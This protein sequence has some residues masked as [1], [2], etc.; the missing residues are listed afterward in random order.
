M[1]L[2]L[3]VLEQ[4]QKAADSGDG[5]PFLDSW[6]KD[7]VGLTACDSEECMQ[8]GALYAGIGPP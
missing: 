1:Q 4:R 8:R 2:A 6:P 5:D 7:Q 3:A